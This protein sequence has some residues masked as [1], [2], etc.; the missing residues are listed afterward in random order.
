MIIRD[1]N[2][3]A[4]AIRLSHP[5]MDGR[6]P[7]PQPKGGPHYFGEDQKKRFSRPQSTATT[8][9]EPTIVLDSETPSRTENPALKSSL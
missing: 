1:S 9:G 7:G 4:I 6:G 3:L 5:G 2:R 8:K